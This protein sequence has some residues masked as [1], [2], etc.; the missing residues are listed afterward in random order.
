MDGWMDGWVGGWRKV[1]TLNNI[2]VQCCHQ[3]YLS[4]STVNASSSSSSGVQGDF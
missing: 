3:F 2:C 4:R 1:R